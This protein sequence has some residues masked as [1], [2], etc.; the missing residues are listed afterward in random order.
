VKSRVAPL[1]LLSALAFSLAVSSAFAQ[2][3]GP[4]QCIATS[5]DGGHVTMYLSQMIPSGGASPSPQL[6]HAW[7]DFV[8]SAYNL[9]NVAS[10]VCRA[11]PADPA[12]QQRVM[13]AYQRA[14]QRGNMQLVNVNWTPG[15]NQNNAPN[16]N[17]NPYAAAGGGGGGNGGGKDA[18]P[19]DN[20]NAPAQDQGNQGPPPRASYCFS[21]QKKPTVYFS[22]A[23]DTADIQNPDDWV[24]AFVKML[25][26]KYKYKGTVTCNDN[27]TIFNAQSAIRDL[28]DTM[29]GK[30][31]IDTD[32][33]YEP[34]AP[35][36]APPADAAPA[37]APPPKKKSAAK[38]A[39]QN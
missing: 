17:T 12:V 24:N 31:L 36:E 38:P 33:T 22:D 11:M 23:F 25:V 5:T 13:D 16:A 18:P 27:D 3:G 28:K 29:Q 35:G 30:Q 32:W 39:P 26:D 6:N 2:Q 34:P 9:Q 19:A 14:A 10:A 8:K 37:P 21:D 4:L 7:S 20:Q 1:V 15:Q